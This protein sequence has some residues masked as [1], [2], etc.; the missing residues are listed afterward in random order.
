MRSAKPATMHEERV[1]RIAQQICRALREAHT[2]GVIHRDLKPANIFLSKHGDDEDFVKVLDFGLVKHLG[3]RPEEQLTQTG[4][5]M[6]SPKYMAP[7]QIQGGQVDARTDIY[8]LGI[9]MYEMLAGK[10]PFERPT[11]REHPDGARRRAAAADARGEPEHPLLAELRGD[12]DALHREGPERAPTRSMDAVLQAIKRAH[13]VSMTGQLAA[14]NISGEYVPM[15]AN[16]P[17]AVH[18]SHRPLGAHPGRLQR[19]AYADGHA[20]RRAAPAR[21]ASAG[22]TPRRA[23]RGRRPGSASASSSPPRS[24]ACSGWSRFA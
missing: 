5:F 4:L 22:R 21:A 6:G 15:G 13:G 23:L 8:S 2:L 19:L 7:E 17:P 11:Q 1:G 24:A 18:S 10:V 3:E 20:Q 16:P 9:M 14:V 12:R